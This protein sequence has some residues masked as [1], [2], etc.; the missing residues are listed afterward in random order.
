MQ[1]G[2]QFKKF[3]VIWHERV[4]N[5]E[6]DFLYFEKKSKVFHAENEDE[7]CEAWESET[8]PTLCTQGIIDCY[9]VLEGDYLTKILTFK[10][11]S[12]AVYG[13]R[14]GDL[15][16]YKARAMIAESATELEY[17]DV[18][19]DV[20]LEFENIN[21]VYEYA[22][23]IKWADVAEHGFRLEPVVHE[24]DISEGWLQGNF[25]MI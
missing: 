18:F 11:K 23:S 22:L 3:M 15:A 7:A 19:K 17:M 5:G 20:I 24:S 2:N 8:D 4:L 25:S 10:L 6:G 21:A 16:R 12:G 13:I 1:N 14:L 9:E